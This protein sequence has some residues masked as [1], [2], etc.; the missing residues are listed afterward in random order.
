MSE[1]DWEPEDEINDDRV[2]VFA[3]ALA[4]PIADLIESLSLRQI[5][6]AQDVVG[7]HENGYCIS[8]LVLSVLAFESLAGRVSHLRRRDVGLE[9]QESSTLK[10]L[11]KVDPAFPLKLMEDLVD[12]YLLRDALAHGHIWTV[13]YTMGRGGATVTSRERHPGYGDP[14]HV[15]RVDGNKGVTKNL[16]LN[17]LPSEIG[18]R[19][20]SVAMRTLAATIQR[21]VDIG[22][23]ELPA[24]VRRVKYQGKYIGFWSLADE[25][26]RLRELK[27]KRLLQVPKPSKG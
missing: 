16:G 1:D 14:K 9:R 23:V 7:E 20:A 6:S 12:V 2:T 18:L 26:D 11:R 3:G 21:L 15:D 27:P 10:F 25:L 13:K 19:E 17:V 8:I 22:A 24:V 4:Q 5:K